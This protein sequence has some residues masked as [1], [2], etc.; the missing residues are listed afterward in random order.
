[1]GFEHPWDHDETLTRVTA[2][3]P[4]RHLDAITALVDAGQ[5]AHR[6]EAIRT[7]ISDLLD[8]TMTANDRNNSND[9]T[10]DELGDTT[11]HIDSHDEYLIVSANG[12]A[13]SLDRV[14]LDDADITDLQDTLADI[15]QAT[16][17]HWLEEAQESVEGPQ[18]VNA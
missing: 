5:Y 16:I 6:S 10:H 8:S 1:M 12:V 14:E 11:M 17:A 9:H 3:V 2:R 7:A 4:E 13:I 15:G 18:V